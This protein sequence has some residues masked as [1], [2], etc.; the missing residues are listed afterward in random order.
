LRGLP[1]HDV[2]AAGSQEAQVRTRRIGSLDVT[3]IGVGC[4]NF[5]RQLDLAA[6]KPI[7]EAAIEAG[8][9]LFDTA[10]AYGEPKTESERVLGEALK[11]HRRRV[12]IAT[13][14]GRV[15]DDRRRGA[16]ASYVREATEASLRRLQ[17]DYI[18]LMQLHIPDPTTP[19][20]ET[21]GALRDLMKE[22]KIRE[23]G[24]SNFSAAQLREMSKTARARGLPAFASTQAP[25]SLL[26]RKPVA[27]LLEECERSGVKLLPYQPLFNGLLTG[28]YKRGAAMD[29]MS[30]IGSKKADAQA[31]IMSPSNLA[32][33]DALTAYA[34]ERGRT[35]L[36]LAIGWLLGH[37]AIPSVI[38]GVSSPAQVRS[39]VA[40]SSWEL[41]GEEMA[42]ITA[43]IDAHAPSGD[44]M[45]YSGF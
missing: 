10:D 31:Q 38:A 16:G 25:Y 17:T 24:A 11:P 18:D 40:S 34:E 29:A 9:N 22:G 1:R 14:F 7:V 2:L 4:N 30:R 3:V 12:L 28:K 19:I 45:K 13:K 8:V 44:L 36:E 23:I 15:L 43:I 21:L 5:G 39:N 20:E 6:T 33:V 27:G 35:M 41:G 32:T 42:G 26:Y 37:P